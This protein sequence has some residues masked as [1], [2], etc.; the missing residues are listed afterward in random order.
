[1]LIGKYKHAVDNRNRIFIPAKFRTDIGEKCVVS[2]DII[3]SCLN[4][5][6]IKQ[7]EEFTK[8]IETL[9]TVLMRDLRAMIYPNSDEVD[10]DSQGRIILNQ[11]LCEDIGIL[12]AKEVI[13]TGVH[14]HAQIWNTAE[15]E[16]FSSNIKNKEN[17][18]SIITEL[19]KIGF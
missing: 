5:Y 2:K 18:E 10:T 13:I 15:W 16:N 12:N 1:M 3:Y 19:L 4:I 8:K 9:P 7:W 11:Q 14:T 6:P 17:K